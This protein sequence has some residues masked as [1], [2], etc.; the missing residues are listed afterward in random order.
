[1]RSRC[2]KCW[3]TMPDSSFG[4]EN[5]AKKADFDS[6]DP[7]LLKDVALTDSDKTLLDEINARIVKA[8]ANWN[9]VL[10]WEVYQWL[11]DRIPKFVYFGEY[12]ILPSKINLNDLA[13]RSKRGASDPSVLK[14]EHKAMLALLRMADI[15]IDD[16]ADTAGYES[17]KAKIEGVSISL[18]DQIMKF[19]KQNEDLEVEVD[20][21]ADPKDRNSLQQWLQSLH[22]HQEP[23]SPRRKH[24]LSATK[25]GLRSFGLVWFDSAP[26]T[27]EQ[28]QTRTLNLVLL[29]DEPGLSLHALAQDD[30]MVCIEES[31]DQLGCERE[32]LAVISRFRIRQCR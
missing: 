17:L 30:F 14:P 29:L 24:A 4:R 22:P 20:I 13:D 7:D 11:C 21:K 28:S 31:A 12:E 10:T 19:W 27:R 3:A 5:R 32:S 9:S 6:N 1:M 16:F 26:S 8:Q 2:L 25:S 15:S 18:T 23:P